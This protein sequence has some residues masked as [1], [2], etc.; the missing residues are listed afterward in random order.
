MVYGQVL[1]QPDQWVDSGV[2]RIDDPD[3]I[4]G[5][6]RSSL[7]V[8]QA[9]ETPVVPDDAYEAIEEALIETIV[10]G[11]FTNEESTASQ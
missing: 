6:F 8:T 3:I 5:L 9:H 1:P 4:R 11:L 7:F 2:T 10:A